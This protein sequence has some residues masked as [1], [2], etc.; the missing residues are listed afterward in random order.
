LVQQQ[1]SDE[2]RFAL[3]SERVQRWQKKLI[4]DVAYQKLSATFSAR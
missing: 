1:A 4:A 3:M 2:E